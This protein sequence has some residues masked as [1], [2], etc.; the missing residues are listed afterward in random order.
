MEPF[1]VAAVTL[2][3]RTS[4]VA[5]N[6]DSVMAWMRKAAEAGARLVLFPEGILSGYDLAQIE[7]SSL[8][9]D[10]PE[11]RRLREEAAALGVCVSAGYLERA[12]GVFFV[13]QC[14]AGPGGLWL[15][16]RKCHLTESERKACAAGDRLAVQ[17]LG[18]VRMGVQ[19]C[20][21]SAFPR[22]SETLVRR[23][24]D[25]LFT[26]TC[27]CFYERGERRDYPAALEKRRR[28]VNTYWRARAY[29]YSTYAIYADAVGETE[30]G[31]WFPGYV[32]VFGPDGEVVAES[33]AG[34]EAMVIADLDPER[35]DRCRREW[36]GHY[37][38]LADARPEL[39]EP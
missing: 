37:R 33:V 23:G 7:R 18:F 16:Y 5:A 26:P 25:L 29:D 20:Y 31:E 3:P 8:R 30:A 9:A 11:L 2:T 39:Y 17:D 38:S 36:V 15:N 35:Q 12:D 27:H 28:H 21:D 13:S 22:A 19:I 32:A 1:R 4:R 10:G 14:A 24:A 6:L 34:E